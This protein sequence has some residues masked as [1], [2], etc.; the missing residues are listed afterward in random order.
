MSIRTDRTYLHLLAFLKKLLK[1]LIPVFNIS[2]S[3]N[4]VEPY[5]SF[6]G[7]I[8]TKEDFASSL[9]TFMSNG[10]LLLFGKNAIVSVGKLKFFLSVDFGTK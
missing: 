3:P 2:G 1:A 6:S 9:V 4:S 10:S 8:S 5:S 7:S